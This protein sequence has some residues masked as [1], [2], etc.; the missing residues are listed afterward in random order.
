MLPAQIN[1]LQRDINA[2]NTSIY[3]AT[4]DE[5]TVKAETLK[6]KKMHM[7]EQKDALCRLLSGS[8]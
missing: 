5:N 7:T 1:R 3:R 2:M 4:R 8:V 6:G